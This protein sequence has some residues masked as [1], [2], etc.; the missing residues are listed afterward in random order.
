MNQT[1]V[2]IT[3]S[4]YT[5]NTFLLLQF[6]S[7]LFCLFFF[8]ATPLRN[9]NNKQ[10][11]QHQDRKGSCL[12]SRDIVV[13]S[14]WKQS[15]VTET[16]DVVREESHKHTHQG[17]RGSIQMWQLKNYLPKK[18]IRI[19]KIPKNKQQ[20][21]QN[22]TWFSRETVVQNTQLWVTKPVSV[23]KYTTPLWWWSINTKA[24]CVI[25]W[26]ND[27]M[28]LNESFF[29]CFVFRCNKQD[30]VHNLHTYIWK[31]SLLLLAD[32]L[33]DLAA[34]IPQLNN[35]DYSLQS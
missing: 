33:G 30:I 35:Q 21:N 32:Q 5:V 6:Y 25:N 27:F 23:S 2:V 26:L 10:T 31:A 28:I 12:Q 14:R 11:H 3:R 15:S 16:T 7:F 9:K 13:F 22:K 17:W 20:K 1:I 4:K 29:F 34:S 8:L 24:A 18:K 19:I